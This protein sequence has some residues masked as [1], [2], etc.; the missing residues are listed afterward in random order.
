[1]TKM[2]IGAAFAETFA[3]LKGNWMQM[4]MWLGGAVVIACILGWLLLRNAMGAMAMGPAAD[5]SSVVGVF[6]SFILFA[7]IAGTILF[8]A[9]LLIWRSGLVG[10]DPVSDIGWGLGAGAAYMLAML[11]VYIGTIIAMYIVLAIVGL[12]AFAVFGASGMSLDS[13]AT[14]SASA[15]LLLFAVL[16]YLAIIVFFMWFFGRLS[17]AGPLMAVSRSTNPFSAFAE[18]WRMTSASQWTIVG[19]NILMAILFAVA[20]FLVTLVLGSF[21]SAMM[22]PGAGAGAAI[23]GLIAALL[24]YVPTVLVSVSMPAGV[25]RCISAKTGSDVFA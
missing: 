7:L 10:G 25:Y 17:V 15:G 1:M 5:P 20:V 21:T 9:S 3:F 13:L 18:S 2:S 6:G 16:I 11:V 4:L 23:G 19:F 24:I 14:G 8:A 22:A 12:I